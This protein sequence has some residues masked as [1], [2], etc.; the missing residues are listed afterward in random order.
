MTYTLPSTQGEKVQ[1]SHRL[2][3]ANKI[4]TMRRALHE[5]ELAECCIK[6]ALPDVDRSTRSRLTMLMG[7]LNVE[8]DLMRGDLNSRGVDDGT[9]VE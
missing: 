7:Q 1:N 6:C 5:L 3:A 9:V 4:P 8:M 2:A